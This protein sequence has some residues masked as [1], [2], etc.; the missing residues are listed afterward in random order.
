MDGFWSLKYLYD[1]MKSTF[2]AGIKMD[3]ARNLFDLDLKFSKGGY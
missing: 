2:Y 1:P 3:N